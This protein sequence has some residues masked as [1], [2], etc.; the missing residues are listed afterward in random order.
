MAGVL[1]ALASYVTNMLTKMAREDVA[2]LIGVSDEINDLSIKLKDLKNFLGDA[3][4]R[5]ITDESIR[6]VGGGTEVC[7]VPRYR[8]HRPMSS[9]GHGAR[10]IQ[11]YRVS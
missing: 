11:G 9:Q 3:N 10:S 4:R 6:G 2:M 1:D 7:H 8:H 5:N